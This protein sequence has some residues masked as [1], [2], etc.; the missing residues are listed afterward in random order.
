MP[1]T[2]SDDGDP[3]DV[4]IASEVPF[5]PGCGARA[6]PGRVLLMT[7]EAEP[8][9]KILSVPVDTLHPY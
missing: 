9:E 6:Q 7:D 3:I 1:H 5:L 2:L 8:D 4:L